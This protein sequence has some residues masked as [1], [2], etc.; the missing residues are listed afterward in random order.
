MGGMDLLGNPAGAAS[1]SGPSLVAFDKGGFKVSMELSKPDASD[2]S[3]TRI[4]CKFSNDCAF[5][6]TN[7]VFQVSVPKYLTLLE[8]QPASGSMCPPKSADSVTQV[9]NVSNTMQGQ[10]NITLRVK[11]VYAL[12]NQSVD[13]VAVISNFPALY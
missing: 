1:P 13:E 7:L 11:I 2:P 8:M 3:K 12:N 4:L 6:I 5:P 9:V 10:K